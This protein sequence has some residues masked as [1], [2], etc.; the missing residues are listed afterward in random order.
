MFE[1]IA[2]QQPS[3]PHKKGAERTLIVFLFG[4]KYA[5]S[6]GCHDKGICFIILQQINV[7]QQ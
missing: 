3:L 2:G 6:I 1:S 7:R 4:S 5:R